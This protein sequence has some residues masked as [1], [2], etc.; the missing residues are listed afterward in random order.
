M[1][2]FPFEVMFA[3]VLVGALLP[4][5]ELRPEGCASGTDLFLPATWFSF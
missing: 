2:V 4:D 3:W 1:R 5:D